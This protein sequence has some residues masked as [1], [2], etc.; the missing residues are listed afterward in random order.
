LVLLVDRLLSSHVI[1][2]SFLRI[3]KSFISVL[4]LDK[5]LVGKLLFSVVVVGVVFLGQLSVLS[6][7]LLV[8]EVSGHSEDL[9]IILF[10]QSFANQKD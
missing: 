7:Q 2:L 5:F 1:S 8:I 10:E 9:I 3:F 4:N 6:L